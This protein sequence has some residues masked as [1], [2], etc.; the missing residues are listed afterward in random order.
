MGK[1]ATNKDVANLA[2][3]SVATVSY[4]INGREDMRIPEVTRKKVMQAINFLGY[5]PNPFAANLMSGSHIVAVRT[6]GASGPLFD[7][8][9]ALFTR[10]LQNVM[11]RD[12]YG[13]SLQPDSRAEKLP[14]E[15]CVAFHMSREEFHALGNENFIPL[16]AV[17]CL[18]NDPVFYQV[19]PDYGKIKAAADARFNAPYSYV[20]LK[21]AD[22]FARDAVLSVFPDALFVS[23][24]GEIRRIPLSGKNILLTHAALFQAFAS[25]SGGR[26]VLRYDAHL[27]ARP[28]IVC[29]CI[30]NAVARVVAPDAAHF[31]EV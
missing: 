14:A 30:K 5:S 6:L 18:I 11:R 17:D 31:I 23:D 15:A 12:N 25:V 29:D 16:V 27:K 26:N 28:Q 1:R 2:G 3:V 21:P 20:A 7:L 8:E 24:F 10:E 13:V 19:M 22:E 9:A 4:V